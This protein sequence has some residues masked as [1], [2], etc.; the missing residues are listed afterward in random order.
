[1]KKS[2]FKPMR[3]LVPLVLT[4]IATAAYAQQMGAHA[5]WRTVVM[6]TNGMAAAEHPI[7]ALAGARVLEAGGNAVDAAVAVF[8]ATAVVE[9]HQAGLGGDALM[10]AYVAK[11]GKVV[12]V[13]GTGFAPKLATVER[14]KQAGGIPEHGALA[15]LVP[16]AVGGFDLA[17]KTYGTKPLSELVKTAVEAAK[18]H[19]LTYFAAK[20]GEAGAP[21]ISRHPATAAIFLREGKAPSAGELLVQ[22]DLAKTIS[23]M[24]EKGADIFYRGDLARRTAEFSQKHGGLI[25]VDDL[26]AYRA[27][28]AEPIRTSYKGYEVYQ[29]AP[30]SQG[31]VLLMALNILESFD[32]KKLG[33]NTPEYIHTVVEALKLA[34]ADRD[35]YIA[36][37]RFVKDI[38]VAGLLSKDYA[39]ARARLISADRAIRGVAPAGDPR[40]GKAVVSGVRGSDPA[41]ARKTL[42]G[43]SDGETSS[44][45]IAD[46]F[47]NLVSV[48]H[49]VNGNFGSGMAV[50][51][52]GFLLN[53]RMPYFSLEP[54]DVNVLEPRKRPRHTINPA[55]ALKD[56]K[57]VMAWN[58][59]G[60]DNQPQAMLQAFLN[61]VEFGMNL[62]IALESPT[63][64]TAAFRASMYPQKAG[65]ALTVPEVLAGRVAED[66]RKKGHDVRV[67][68]LQQPYFMQPSGAGAVKMIRIDPRTGVMQG[69]VSPAKD[70]YVIGW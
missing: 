57:P 68:A 14:Y 10:L 19:P 64:T 49:S 40:S 41:A 50:E 3:M 63:V 6:G 34:F 39:R 42:G 28:I 54:G 44:F 8:Y 1:M 27:E 21:L 60:G 31:I 46:R 20:S 59:P 11:Q 48:T 51:G 4:T 32:L 45:S 13:N 56:G 2:R 55:M 25:R 36:D 33:H 35:R 69:G 30:N 9:Q 52:S 12:F 24:A 29:S 26:A 58:T 18:G 47:G 16:G 66:L 65:E 15:S 37:P 7:E 5:G 67:S 23:T 43:T 53:N 17:L 62:Q 22:T 70:N 38:P 61:V